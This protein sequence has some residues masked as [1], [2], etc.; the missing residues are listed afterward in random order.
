MPIIYHRRWNT[1]C[2]NASLEAE[3]MRF[4]KMFLRLLFG[5]TLHGALLSLGITDT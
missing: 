2:N 4:A 1:L 5:P 3:N